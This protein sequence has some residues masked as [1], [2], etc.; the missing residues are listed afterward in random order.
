[1]QGMITDLTRSFGPTFLQHVIFCFVRMP[2]TKSNLRKW[3]RIDRRELRKG[4]ERLYGKDL[5]D[6][7]SRFGQT[8]DDFVQGSIRINTRHEKWPNLTMKY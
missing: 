2:F 6:H 5:E 8:I 4:K 7:R 3:S 1:V